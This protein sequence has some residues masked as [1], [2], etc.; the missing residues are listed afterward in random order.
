MNEAEKAAYEKGRLD[1]KLNNMEG[2]LREHTDLHE[3]TDKR[4]YALE[5]VDLILFALLAL[6]IGQP[7]LNLLV[8]LAYEKFLSVGP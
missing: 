1:E 2:V 7:I 3:A 5:R 8:Q 6:A 4:L